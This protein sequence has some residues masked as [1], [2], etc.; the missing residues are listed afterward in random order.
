M[1]EKRTVIYKY[2][3]YIL[4]KFKESPDFLFFNLFRGVCKHGGACM[5]S[6]VER[7]LIKNVNKNAK[8]FGY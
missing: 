6:R 2:D 4:K 7:R 8:T 5:G 1:Y 3:K